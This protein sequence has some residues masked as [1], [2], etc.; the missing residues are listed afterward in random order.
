VWD[1]FFNFEEAINDFSNAIKLDTSNAVYWHNRACCFRNMGALDKSIEDFNK[2]V[3]L[4]PQN[5][6]IYSNRG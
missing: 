5:A 2:A 6:I 4:D 3:H 1:R